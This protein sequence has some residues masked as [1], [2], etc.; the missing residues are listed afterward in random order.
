MRQPLINQI[1]S[2]EVKPSFRTSGIGQGPIH[3][4]YISYVSIHFMR[5]RSGVIPQSCQT[6]P[7]NGYFLPLD[8]NRKHM[9]RWPNPL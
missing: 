2:A 3:L 8:F 5:C 1:L 9:N 6:R 4:L 7:K